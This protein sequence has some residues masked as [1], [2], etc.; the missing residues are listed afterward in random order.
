MP[1]KDRYRDKGRAK[2]KSWR[3]GETKQN[4]ASGSALRRVEKED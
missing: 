4:A 2:R 1:V 3:G